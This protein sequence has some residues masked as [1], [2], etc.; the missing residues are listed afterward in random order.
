MERKDIADLLAATFLEYHNVPP[1]DVGTE[2]NIADLLAATFLEYHNV[3]PTDVG[4]ED[5]EVGT[6]LLA[7][8][9][10]E[11]H[12]VPPTDVGTEDTEVGSSV[13][14]FLLLNPPHP[15]DSES[16]LTT[17]RAVKALVQRTP[18]VKAY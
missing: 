17:P 12:N 4:T 15:H 9:F 2:D 14:S 13:N 6:D 1:T 8:T 7:A 16:F 3:P 11:Y 10:L 18:S 5:T